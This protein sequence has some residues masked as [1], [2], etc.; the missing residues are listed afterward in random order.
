MPGAQSVRAVLASSVKVICAHCGLPFSVARVAPGKAV[1]CCSGCALAERVRMGAKGASAPTPALAAA[2]G[3][4]FAFFNQVL[5]WLLAVLLERRAVAVEGGV[6]AGSGSGRLL[7]FASLALGLAVWLALA[8]FQAR[9]G[10]RRVLDGLV[11]A[12][13]LAVLALAVFTRRSEL[14]L[15]A[16]A[17]LGVWALRGLARGKVPAKK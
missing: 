6:L 3:V 13:T 12:A 15:V 17:V 14:A 11:L 10:A 9:A 1:Y 8:F 4:G 7:V 2:L 5:F 16:N